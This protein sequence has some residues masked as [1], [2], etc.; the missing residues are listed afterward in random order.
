[1]VS[2]PTVK[3]EEHDI[4]RKL[5]CVFYR[6]LGRYLAPLVRA[7]RGNVF[8]RH[9]CGED[10][11][12]LFGDNGSLVCHQ[13]GVPPG[14]GVDIQHLPLSDTLCVVNEP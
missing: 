13:T 11:V 3:V 14:I 10:T 9:I 4:T 8:G 7:M 6:E 1:M 2:P 12:T 5:I